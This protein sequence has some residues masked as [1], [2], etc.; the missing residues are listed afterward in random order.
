MYV[1][2]QTRCRERT[3]GQSGEGERG[4]NEEI[5]TD[6]RTLPCVKQ[7][8]GEAAG[9]HGECISG[10]CNDLGGGWGMGGTCKRERIYVYI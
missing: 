7:P 9:Q 6:I 1:F 5:R 2:I 10:L 4:T 3:C 8:A